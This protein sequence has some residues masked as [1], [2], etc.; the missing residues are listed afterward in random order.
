MWA[1]HAGQPISTQPSTI[2]RAGKI[3]QGGAKMLSKSCLEFR[4][5]YS[6]LGSRKSSRKEQLPI[7]T[8]PFGISSRWRAIV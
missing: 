2:Q 3:G 4:L 8:T 1:H 6:V 5:I 7:M